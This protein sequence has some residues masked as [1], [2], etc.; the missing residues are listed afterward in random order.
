MKLLNGKVLA[1]DPNNVK[2]L[3]NIGVSLNKLEK[4]E[5]SIEYADKALA[6]QPND[7]IALKNKEIALNNLKEKEDI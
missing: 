7:V 1:L 3:G 6:I 2:A 5:E 4:Y